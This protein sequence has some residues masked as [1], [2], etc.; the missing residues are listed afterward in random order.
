M[1]AIDLLLDEENELAFQLNIEGTQPG[2]AVCRLAVD[3]PDIGLLFEGRGLRNGEISV[4][5]PPLSHVLKEGTYDMTLEVIVDD[6]F[7]TPLTVKGNFEKSVSVTA[8]A[9]VRSTPRKKTTVTA[10]PIV[11]NK[12]KSKVKNSI[13]ENR[14]VRP[15]LASDEDIMKLVNALTN[16]AKSKGKNK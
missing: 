8:E 1:S 7:F 10:K 5:L 16:V 2:Q 14:T 3:S 6:K 15:N 4:I 13:S 12:S 9:V 11:E